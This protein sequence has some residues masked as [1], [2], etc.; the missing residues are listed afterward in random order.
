M[1]RSVVRLQRR[2]G[3]QVTPTKLRMPGLGDTHGG[4]FLNSDL[5]SRID[6]SSRS[7]SPEACRR[8]MRYLS[9]TANLR[10]AVRNARTV[11]NKTMR[12]SMIAII[13]GTCISG[14][15]SH[16]KPDCGVVVLRPGAEPSAEIA[17]P[18]SGL[19]ER[20]RR[21]S[22]ERAGSA[23]YH[24]ARHSLRRQ[25]GAGPSPVEGT[26]LHS[27]VEIRQRLPSAP[28]PL[29]RRTASLSGVAGISA[30]R[31]S[32]IHRSANSGRTEHPFAADDYNTPPAA[33][34]PWPWRAWGRRPAGVGRTAR[35][36]TNTITSAPS[37]ISSTSGL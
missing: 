26:A 16:R 14:A 24:G 8:C 4:H 34:L 1:G 36:P 32:G 35:A 25:V 6:G 3:L 5:A 23:L 31:R 15:A 29:R 9:L 13:L 22:C 11:E 12:P 20:A 33:S 37:Q 10:M 21:R 18:T 19:R 27:N 7:M 28:C 2:A 17:A 30:R